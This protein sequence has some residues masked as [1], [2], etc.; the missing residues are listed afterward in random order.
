MKLCRLFAL[1]LSGGLVAEGEVGGDST[2]CSR[3]L[4]SSSAPMTM[5]MPA[6]GELTISLH[7]VNKAMVRNGRSEHKKK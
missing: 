1:G 2:P 7:G 6:G 3:R 5:D 4:L